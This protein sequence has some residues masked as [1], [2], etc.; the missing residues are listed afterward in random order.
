M[1][2]EISVE[3]VFASAR[4]QKLVA[5]RLPEDASV[6]DAITESGLQQEFENTDLAELPVGIWG[7]LVER[8]DSLQDGDRVEIYRPLTRD[9]KEARR[10]L[11]RIQRLGSSS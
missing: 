9:P 1:A 2:S 3:I 8:S 6:G 5:L 4:R 10:E 11:A 7:R